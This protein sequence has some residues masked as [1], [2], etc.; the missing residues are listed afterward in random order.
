MIVFL[1]VQRPSNET[2]DAPGRIGQQE[3]FIISIAGSMAQLAGEVKREPSS[4][5]RRRRRDHAIVGPAR[6]DGRASLRAGSA[7]RRIV[8]TSGAA[9]H[10]PLRMSG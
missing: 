8:A 4:P 10:L 6:L 1:V 3:P 7:F 5:V 9:V 2:A